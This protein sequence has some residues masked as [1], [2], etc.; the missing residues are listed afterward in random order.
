MTAWLEAEA[1]FGNDSMTPQCPSSSAKLDS[2]HG[3]RHRWDEAVSLIAAPGPVYDKT[4][5]SSAGL[6]LTNCSGSL[7]AAPLPW[8]DP[9]LQRLRVARLT[10]CLGLQRRSYIA[11]APDEAAGALDLDI[12]PADR[13]RIVP[14]PSVFPTPALVWYLYPSFSPPPSCY[15]CSPLAGR[16]VCVQAVWLLLR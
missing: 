16:P 3:A 6:Q 15:C 10:D 9:S 8:Y 5:G 11:V 12:I 2:R 7:W 13:F 1:V 14:I 4:H